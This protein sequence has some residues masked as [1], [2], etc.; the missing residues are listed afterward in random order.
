MMEAFLAWHAV[1]Y[2]TVGIIGLYIS[3]KLIRSLSGIETVAVSNV[4][5]VSRLLFH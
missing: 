4:R 3:T 2:I 5:K 1:G